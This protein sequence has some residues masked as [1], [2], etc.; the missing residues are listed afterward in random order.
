VVFAQRKNY[1]RWFEGVLRECATRKYKESEC[2]TCEEVKAH[3]ERMVE[4]M[5]LRAL[6]SRRTR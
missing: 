2:F 1:D 6:V 3:L 5:R 4:V